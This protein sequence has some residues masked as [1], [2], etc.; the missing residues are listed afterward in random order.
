MPGPYYGQ[1]VEIVDSQLDA[2][3]R[4]P[5]SDPSYVFDAQLTYDLQPLLYEPL[6]AGTG[7]TVTHDGVNR[8]A[9][10]TFASTPTGGQAILQTFEYFRYQPGRA[11]FVL[12]TF[13]L[14]GGVANTLKFALYGDA[15]NAIGLELNGTVPR[16]V[17]RSGS[18]AG[19]QFVDQKDWNLDKCDGYGASKANI[20]FTKTQILVLDFQALYVGRVRVGFDIDG[21][22][23]WAH[24]FRN[25]N[26][27]QFPYIQSANLPIRV[28]M[29]CTGTVS[30]TMMFI[31]TSV[32]SGGGE[33]DIGG[34]NFAVEGT[35]TAGSSIDAHILS[36]R[37]STTFNSITNRT[38]FVLESVDVTVTGTPPVVW[39]LCLGQ[40]ITAPTWVNSNAT[41]SAFEKTTAGVISGAPAIVIAKGFCPATATV[42][43]TI[44]KIISARY[45]I[46]LNAAGA[47]RA[48]GT[49][50]VNALGVGG[51][52]A[53]RVILNWRE[54]R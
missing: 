15:T 43:Q 13:N 54:I 40:V 34:Y 37:P 29:T 26:Y 1:K 5:V 48:L 23:I 4:L 2:F 45:P 39:S 21:R 20:D 30:T 17:I 31:C 49:L 41:Y 3:G 51:T 32:S 52:S 9:L 7:A 50:S 25:A 24:E 53:C 11:Q 46:T 33:T 18:S 6:T 42:K 35:G 27:Q 10:M 28:G 22:I 36:V 12:I 8:C 14:L 47:V 38:K 19:G 44:S 16:M